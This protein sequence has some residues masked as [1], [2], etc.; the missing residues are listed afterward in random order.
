M[1]NIGTFEQLID[2]MPYVMAGVMGIVC[3]I[4]LIYGIYISIFKKKDKRVL[5]RSI[6]Y[7]VDIIFAGFLVFAITTMIQMDAGE[8]LS[9]KQCVNLLLTM[10]G[11]IVFNIL[12]YNNV[13]KDKEQK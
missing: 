5:L 12:G 9:T 1:T 13:I 7:L 3:I 11:I 10:V 8:H 4:I 6:I 2:K